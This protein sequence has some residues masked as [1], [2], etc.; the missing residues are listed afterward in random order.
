MSLIRKL[1]NIWSSGGTLESPPP[2]A[3]KIDLGFVGDERPYIDR[4][5]WLQNRA[6]KK[7]NDLLVNGVSSAYD[8][9][10]EAEVKAM[11]TTGLW[12]ESWGL[13]LD[14]HN[15]IS[16]GAAKEYTD[17]VNTFDADGEPLLL[18][19]D[20]ALTKIEVWNP[21][22]LTLSDTSH[23]LSGDIIAGTWVAD[24]MCTDGTHVFVTF[25]D[26]VS[27]A[28]H[29]HAW[30]ISDW[31]KHTGWPSTGTVLPGTGTLVGMGGGK[32]I[33]IASATKIVTMN[34]W[35]TVTAASSAA[36]SIIDI[37]A[38]TITASGAGDCPTGDSCQSSG[39]I[40][41]D[42][43]NVFF[44]AFGNAGA[45]HYL[46]SA[47]VAAPATGCGGTGY[48]D[49]VGSNN[50]IQSLVQCG[51]DLFVSVRL[52]TTPSA[53]HIPI[54]THSASNVNGDGLIL[55]QS[56]AP[57]PT[58]GDKYVLYKG[59]DTVFDGINFWVYGYIKNYASAYTGVALRIS[60]AEMMQAMHN[61]ERQLSDIADVFYVTPDSP[62]VV[63][64]VGKIVFDGRDIWV[65]PEYRA[66][67]TLSGQIRRLPLALIRS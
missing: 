20:E 13:S 62:V 54:K 6:E 19:L 60:A 25:W 3:A 32:R 21:R 27:H 8:N 11:L 17:M 34:S 38:G 28:H 29:I 23:D 45:S 59:I 57:T 18:V 41:S 44:A 12:D 31:S 16:G 50:A 51:P 63:G 65:I 49:N 67:Q 22:T 15:T 4:F 14:A 48:P 36:I 10:T 30:K 40:C 7:L 47:Q 9:A 61:I 2:S 66:S 56:S 39:G 35:V 64:D 52:H 26:T 55:G 24:S 53:S 43:T 46:C 42:G 58:G 33:I 1:L 37:A 5:N